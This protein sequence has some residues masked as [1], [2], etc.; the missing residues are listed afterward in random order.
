M[1]TTQSTRFGNRKPFFILLFI[2][3]LFL[4]PAVV[5]WLWNG[6]LPEIIGVKM[7]T[8]WQSMGIIV[9]SRILFGSFGF[10]GGHRKRPF[11]NR[12]WKDKWMEMSEDE[13]KQFKEEWDKRS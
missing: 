12:Q 7:I 1:R 11:A 8:Y 2:G 5:M 4:M 3:F 10:G 13:K 6:L 9:L